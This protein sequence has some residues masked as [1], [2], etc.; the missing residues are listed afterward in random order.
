MRALLVCLYGKLLNHVYL[1][2]YFIS[3][4]IIVAEHSLAKN[5]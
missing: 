2:E 1:N 5:Y 3:Q 4:W